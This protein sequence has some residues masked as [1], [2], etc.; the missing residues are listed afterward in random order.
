M[1]TRKQ[2]TPQQQ[3]ARDE[4]KARLIEM[5][6][7]ISKMTEAQRLEIINSTGAIVTCEGR[8]LSTRNTMLVLMQ[9]P[10]AS[11]V[12][13]FR[14]WQ[15]MGRK[16]SKGTHGAAIL[17]PCGHRSQA[18]DGEAVTDEAGEGGVFFTTT[19]VFDIA[20]TEAIETAPATAAA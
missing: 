7:Q 17:V 3:A 6:R 18:P 11:V 16:V 4:R 1:K 19:T 2:L 10:K 13:G 15:T 9:L 14:Q 8:A 12:G 5:N 20:Q